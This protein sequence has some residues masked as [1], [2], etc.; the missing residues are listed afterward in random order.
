MNLDPR[1]GQLI[2]LPFITIIS[3]VGHK[4]WSFKKS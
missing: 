1:I 3:F 4:R 2:A